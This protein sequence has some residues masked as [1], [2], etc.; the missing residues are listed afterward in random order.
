MSL[1]NQMLRDLQQQNN[2]KPGS[3]SPRKMDR[4]PLLPRSLILVGIVLVLISF[5]WWLSGAMA[6][7]FFGPTVVVKP[8]APQEMNVNRPLRATEETT[9]VVESDQLTMSEREVEPHVAPVVNEQVAVSTPAANV[10]PAISPLR[11]E[12]NPIVMPAVTGV[13][14]FGVT[15]P[16]VS[17]RHKQEVE[18]RRVIISSSSAQTRSAQTTS[19]VAAVPKRLHPDELPGAIVSSRS[20]LSRVT[21]IDSSSRAH[22]T[23]PYGS[24]EEAYLKGKAYVARQLFSEA[25]RSLQQ[26]LVFYPG[27]LPA[28]DLLVDTLSREGKVGEAMFLLAEGLEIAPDYIIFKK[29]YARLLM[30]QGDY[31]AATK[32]MLDDGLPSVNDDPDAHVLLA[33]LYQHLEEPF[34]AAQTYRNL[35]VAWPQTGAFWVGL[36][37]ALEEQLLSEEAVVCYQRALKTKDLRLDL[38]QY[39]EK[40]LGQLN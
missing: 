30:D 14:S 36:G 11:A 25:A 2:D 29:K 37:S 12:S 24:A 5:A 16:P 38:R 23:T 18:S 3:L 31:D 15:H 8:V 7:R 9:R 40:R 4:V 19:R 1:I 26:A 33:S 32:V 27:H 17:T 28:R 39:A 13:K 21:G 35:L 6:D 34:L 20:S 10:S 22:S